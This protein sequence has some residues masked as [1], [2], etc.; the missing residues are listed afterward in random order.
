MAGKLMVWLAAVTVKL[1]VTA[2][3]AAKLLSPGWLACIVHLPPDTTV[4]VAPATVQ[5]AGVVDEKLTGSPDDAVAVT[6]NGAVPN[7]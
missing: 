3:A 4:T 7:T 1:W 6:V 2:T 5:T